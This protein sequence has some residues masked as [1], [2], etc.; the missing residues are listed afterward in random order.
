MIWVAT[1]QLINNI[2]QVRHQP[3]LEYT[4]HTN[5]R[6]PSEAATWMV[7]ASVEMRMPIA[8]ELSAVMPSVA[9]KRPYCGKLWLT[10]VFVWM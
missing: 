2:P 5:A 9:R 8:T 7:G 10:V 3:T 1:H 4:T 6:T